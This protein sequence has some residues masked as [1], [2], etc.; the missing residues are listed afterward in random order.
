DGFGFGQFGAV[1]DAQSA[2]EA[3]LGG[4]DIE[5][6]A[7]RDLND[8]GEIVLALGIGVAHGIEKVERMLA[9]NRHQATVAKGD[10]PLVLAGILVLA[11]G[12][13]P[14]SLFYEASIAGRIGGAEAEYDNGRAL[15]QP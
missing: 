6:L 13:Q 9:G 4:D 14:S 1:V 11:N 8:V 12:D 5:P 3:R 7:A 2:L 15:R 10:A